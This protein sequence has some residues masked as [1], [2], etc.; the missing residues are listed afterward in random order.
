MNEINIKNLDGS[1]ITIK[2]DCKSV[3]VNG[4]M[5]QFSDTIQPQKPLKCRIPYN[6]DKY[7]PI[8]KAIRTGTGMAL[9]ESRTIAELSAVFFILPHLHGDFHR[10]VTENKITF[11]MLDS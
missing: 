11:E 8:I 4:Q 10:F 7:I 6:T 5:F 1:T 9:K 3:N 2:T